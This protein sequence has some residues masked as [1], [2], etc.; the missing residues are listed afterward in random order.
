MT[1][2]EQLEY[3]ADIISGYLDDWVSKKPQIARY[4]W[5]I[6]LREHVQI[7]R[8]VANEVM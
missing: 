5:Y 2:D 6:F 7:L 3:D 8:D 4:H 1:H